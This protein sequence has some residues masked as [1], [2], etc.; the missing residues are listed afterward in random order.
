MMKE[1][2]MEMVDS[3]CEEYGFEDS[4]AYDLLEGMREEEI[5]KELKEYNA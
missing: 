5:V 2:L 4:P 1:K 3:L